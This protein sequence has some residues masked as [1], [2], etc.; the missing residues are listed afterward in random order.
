MAETSSTT[1]TP[2]KAVAD[3]TTEALI[4]AIVQ[5]THMIHATPGDHGED[6]RAQRALA[7]AELIRR[8]E[9]RLTLEATRLTV[10]PA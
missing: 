1:V 3:A 10:V 2:E 5:L 4:D 6:L 9:R 8:D 7:R